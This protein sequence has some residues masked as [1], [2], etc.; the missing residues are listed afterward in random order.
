VPTQ[1]IINHAAAHEL[2]PFIRVGRFPVIK[3]VKQPA[4]WEWVQAF[5][6]HAGTPGSLRC[7]A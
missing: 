2:C 6:A 5:M 1:A 4:D 7:A 3:K